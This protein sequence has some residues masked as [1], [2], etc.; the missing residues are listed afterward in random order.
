MQK[1]QDGETAATL[2]NQLNAI[3]KIREASPNVSRL[4]S[5][6]APAIKTTGEN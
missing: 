3:Q 1:I 2:R 5:T 6:V 4:L